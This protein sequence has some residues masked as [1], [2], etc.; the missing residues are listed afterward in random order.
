MRRAFHIFSTSLCNEQPFKYHAHHISIAGDRWLHRR[1][2]AMFFFTNKLTNH[3][4]CLVAVNSHILV[5]NHAI[6]LDRTWIINFFVFD[7]RAQWRISNFSPALFSQISSASHFATILELFLV[8]MP[9]KPSKT[10]SSVQDVLNDVSDSEF[11]VLSDWEYGE[12]S[13]EEFWHDAWRCWRNKVQDFVY[14]V[15][16]H[17]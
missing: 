16:N 7:A 3:S 17:F 2:L 5:I 13:S 15:L 14:F 12:I 10:Y 1:I 4:S 9:S 8:D 6:L 11:E